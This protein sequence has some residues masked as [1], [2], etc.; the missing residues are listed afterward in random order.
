[1]KFRVWDIK[2]NCY[3]DGVC[4]I[5]NNGLLYSDQHYNCPSE[6]E[7]KEYK[8]EYSSGLLDENGKEIYEGDIMYANTNE[9][10]ICYVE[11]SAMNGFR[12][13][14]RRSREGYNLYQ[15]ETFNILGN[16]NENRNLLEK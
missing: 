6:L 15:T 8:I 16:V 10:E 5:D 9:C 2:N 12:L 13:E 1:M 11:F 4:Y 7:P 3:F 14:S